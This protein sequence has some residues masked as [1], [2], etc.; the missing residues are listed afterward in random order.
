M[1]NLLFAVIQI[2]LKGKGLRTTT[3]FYER[4]QIAL[5]HEALSNITLRILWAPPSTDIC[6][7]S[8]AKYFANIG[9]QVDLASTD[10]VI[11]HEYS[12]NVPQLGIDAD[13]STNEFPTFFAT[14]HELVEYAGMLTLACNFEQHRF[15]NSWKCYGKS[16]EVGSALIIRISGFF[17]F[18]TIE[19]LLNILR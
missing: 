18:E 12:L 4:V 17:G 14:P 3:K 13:E 9:Y 1:N 15:L 19:K 10:Q 5:S 16:K 11:S 2:D 8:V 7:S 6:P